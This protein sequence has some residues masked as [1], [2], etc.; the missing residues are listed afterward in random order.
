MLH[1]WQRRFAIRS[2]FEA[3]F[4]VLGFILEL[5]L[6][7]V[8]WLFRP[9]IRAFRSSLRSDRQKV[10]PTEA[11]RRDLPQ[12]AMDGILAALQADKEAATALPPGWRGFYSAISSESERIGD[13]PVGT[14]GRFI[15]EADKPD[16]EDAVRVDVD[17][18]DR[19]TVQIGYLRR[20]HELGRGIAHGR[21]RCWFA[22]RRRM[23]RADVW[24]AVLF[25]AVY[26]P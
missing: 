14:E 3:I 10:A 8:A 6:E 12:G 24:E 22:A 7:I 25:T 21:V 2:F 5:F 15:L 17:L 23:L 13:V 4:A 16:R 19:S 1:G 9:V 11:K 26:D 20:G 18:P